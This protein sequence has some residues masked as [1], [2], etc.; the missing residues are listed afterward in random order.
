MSDEDEKYLELV[1]RHS[2]E[3]LEEGSQAHKA[4]RELIAAFLRKDAIKSEH[5]P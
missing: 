5:A 3:V 4:F 1:A 2:P